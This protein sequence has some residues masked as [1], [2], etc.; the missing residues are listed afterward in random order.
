MSCNC[1]SGYTSFFHEFWAGGDSSCLCILLRYKRQY[2]S[3][4]ITTFRLSPPISLFY[5]FAGG[6]LV[7]LMGRFMASFSSL[8][9]VAASH[10]S[11]YFSSSCCLSGS[12][13][14]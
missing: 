2:T 3:P 1:C 14:T 7:V 13:F 9:H 12:V 11:E 8:L 4:R 5:M 6:F 10:V